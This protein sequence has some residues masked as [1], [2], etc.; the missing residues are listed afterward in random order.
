[1]KL[2]DVGWIWE[3]QALDPGVHPSIF[4]VGEG[5]EY[6][7]LNK[8]HF[9]FHHTTELALW[10]LRDKEEV[11]CDITKNLPRD[12]GKGG[13][14]ENYWEADIDRV[15]AEA[16][17]LSR[18]SLKFPHVTGAI[19]DDLLFILKEQ[20]FGGEKYAVVSEAL[21]RYN[22]DLKLWAVVYAREVDE[23]EWP[24]IEPYIDIVNLWFWPGSGYDDMDRAVTRCLEVFRGKPIYIGCYMRNYE[25]REPNPVSTIQQRFEGIVRL[26]DEGKIA[27]YSILG[28]TLIDGQLEQAEWIRDF[29]ASHS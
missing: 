12:V 28:T 2:C 27:G 6:F 1:M 16:E 19:H 26:L 29:I 15:C 4:G 7:G 3:G 25:K 9:L 22:K 10:K 17:K 18:L 21:K 23:P 11:V 24:G 5:A 8:C 13:G 20:G 14:S